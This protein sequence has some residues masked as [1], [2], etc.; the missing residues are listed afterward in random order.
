M[1]VHGLMESEMDMVSFIMQMA[2]N[3]KDI[4]KII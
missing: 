2:P 1:K 3:M 4:G